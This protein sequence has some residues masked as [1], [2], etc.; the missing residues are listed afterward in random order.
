MT[1]AEVQ[2][3][4]L[5]TSRR[6]KLLSGQFARCDSS[7]RSI[8]SLEN[9]RCLPSEGTGLS[10]AAL[11][12][13]DEDDREREKHA[14]RDVEE[15]QSATTV[16][17]V[18]DSGAER[19]PQ[20][21]TRQGGQDEEAPEGSRLHERAPGFSAEKGA[22]RGHWIDTLRLGA[23]VQDHVRD[24][25]LPLSAHA[26][27]RIRTGADS[28]GASAGRDRVRRGIRR[29]GALHASLQ[30]GVRT[31]SCTV[32]CVEGQ[33]AFVSHAALGP[34]REVRD[35]PGASRSHAGPWTLRPPGASVTP[36]TMPP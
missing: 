14:H 6:K 7:S 24:Q 16:K 32:P 12:P 3:P 10:A 22:G 27:S 1:S 8:P 36:F 2:Q 9:I 18:L 34:P 35:G 31:D 15:S 25:P 4:T 20:K 23:A 11:S 5:A 19:Q 30:I 17:D 33:S 28:P 29:S 13:D 21:A 26:P